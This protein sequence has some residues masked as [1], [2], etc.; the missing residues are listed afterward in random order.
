M[1]GCVELCG[2]T[3]VKCGLRVRIAGIWGL[4]CAVVE[5]EDEGAEHT[6]LN[7]KDDVL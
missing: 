2:T 1:S 4:L 7:T 5:D 6:Q 3:C